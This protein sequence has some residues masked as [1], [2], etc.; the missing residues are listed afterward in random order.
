MIFLTGASCVG[1]TSIIAE[2]RRILPREDFD[3]HDIDE[4]DLWEESYRTWKRYKVEVWL[5]KSIRNRKKG[6]ETVLCGIIEIEDV[7]FCPSY[8]AASPVKFVFLDANRT[9]LKNRICEKLLDSGERTQ[10]ALRKQM[11]GIGDFK[12]IPTDNLSISETARKVIKSI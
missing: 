9:T 3:I 10:R 11:K 5:R 8:I 2:L 7:I 6:I 4:A 1:K 12:T